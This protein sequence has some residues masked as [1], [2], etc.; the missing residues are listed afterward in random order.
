[1]IQISNFIHR[2]VACP[3]LS[4]MCYNPEE[5]ALNLCVISVT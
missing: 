5:F 2:I 3:D 1:M 4:L